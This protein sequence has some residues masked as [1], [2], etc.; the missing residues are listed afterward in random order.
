[1]A[2][3]GWIAR[4][5]QARKRSVFQIESMQ[6]RSVDRTRYRVAYVAAFG[7]LCAVMTV[8]ALMQPDMSGGEPG[9]NDSD[10]IRPME[11]LAWSIGTPLWLAGVV[12]VERRRNPIVQFLI[13]CALWLPFAALLLLSGDF[14]AGQEHHFFVAVFLSLMFAIRGVS[15]SIVDSIRPMEALGFSG[16]RAA[17]GA[18]IGLLVG[19]AGIPVGM[20][21]EP[22]ADV[23]VLV[24]LPIG[25]LLGGALLG[26]PRSR[27]V[28][29][30]TRPNE[31]M[32]LTA[33]TARRMALLAAVP[34]ATAP[35]AIVACGLGQHAVQYTLAT[36]FPAILTVGLWFGGFDL[37]KHTIVRALVPLPFDL[38]SFMEHARRLRFVRRVGSGY[39]FT[40]RLLR[41]HFA[42]RR[43]E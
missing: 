33:R 23:G 30:K 34:V 27:V 19:A 29:G 39:I 43:A 41:D 25:F 4:E 16:K 3:L 36:L 5:L 1:M 24:G 18:G 6:P 38:P 10:L 32:L 31:G 35:I 22:D 11:A 20:G 9:P 21:Q 26:A 17:I 42:E 7:L 14:M 37:I 28:R 15:H 13:Y 40:H 12:L 8:A 2:A